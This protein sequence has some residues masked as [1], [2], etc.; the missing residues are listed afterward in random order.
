[1]WAHLVSA[2]IGIWLMMSPSFLGYGRPLAT[3]DWI[4]GPLVT[5]VGLIAA[6]EVTRPLRFINVLFAAWVALSPFVLVGERA[7]ATNHVLC[8]VAIGVLSLVRG[9]NK[10]AVA[11]GWR[12]LRQRTP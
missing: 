10:H 12:A 4:V 6:W 8:G 5:S 3:S 1:M 2:S 7:A 11:G 9:R